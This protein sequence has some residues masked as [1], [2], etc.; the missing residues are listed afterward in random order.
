MISQYAQYFVAFVL[1]WIQRIGLLWVNS[2]GYL[3][4]VCEVTMRYKG[5]ICRHQT[6]TQ[7]LPVPNQY[8]TFTDTSGRN[9][10]L[11]LCV[12][13]ICL[14]RISLIHSQ[15]RI[16][17]PS[18][19][20]RPSISTGHALNYVIMRSISIYQAN[21][22]LS[23]TF[24]DWMTKYKSNRLGIIVMQLKHTCVRA[25]VRTRVYLR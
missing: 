17:L 4:V 21:V 14:S 9:L 8:Q 16:H 13:H 24:P 15:I 1:F 25:C 3:L 2:R 20:W 23:S 5:K 18:V 7:I 10:S 6:T 12:Y 11:N 19:K 22:W